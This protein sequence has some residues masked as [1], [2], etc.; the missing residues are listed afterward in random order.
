M[1]EETQVTLTPGGDSLFFQLNGKT[2]AKVRAHH[3]RLGTVLRKIGRA[4]HVEVPIRSHGPYQAW[5]PSHGGV[6]FF[7]RGLIKMGLKP[8]TPS[9]LIVDL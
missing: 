6:A 2:I 3:Y 8:A 5:Q 7:E 4:L 1:Q 9:I